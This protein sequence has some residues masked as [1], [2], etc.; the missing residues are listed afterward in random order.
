MVGTAA[1]PRARPAQRRPRGVW[2]GGVCVRGVSRRRPR[3]RVAAAAGDAAGSDSGSGRAVAVAG[4]GGAA[5]AAPAGP[6]GRARRGAALPPHSR[7]PRLF[8]VRFS[9]AIVFKS[10]FPPPPAGAGRGWGFAWG[11][12]LFPTFPPPFFFFSEANAGTPGAAGLC[13]RA[14]APRSRCQSTRERSFIHL[15]KKKHTQKTR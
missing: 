1:P 2:G 15:K 8:P 5:A 4:P 11:F 13:R 7:T 12:F 6:L 9:A 14:R 3:P 10:R